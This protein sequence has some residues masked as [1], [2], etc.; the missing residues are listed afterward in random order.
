MRAASNLRLPLAA[1]IFPARVATIPKFMDLPSR[2]TWRW[3]SAVGRPWQSPAGVS[4]HSRPGRTGGLYRR[5]S[6]VRPQ[7]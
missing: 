4:D 1:D 7:T 3:V 2:G 5:A 6:T